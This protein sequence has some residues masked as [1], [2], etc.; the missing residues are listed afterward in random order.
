MPE[1][2]PVEFA[3]YFNSYVPASYPDPDVKP[4]HERFGL[5]EN[6]FH[7]NYWKKKEI[8][9]INII[10]NQRERECEVK[11]NKNT[12]AKCVCIIQ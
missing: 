10:N 4:R 12:P 5:D 3:K 7:E 8:E 1:Q 6:E 2:M 11:I 9:K